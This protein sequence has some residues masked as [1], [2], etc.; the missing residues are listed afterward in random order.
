MRISKNRVENDTVTELHNIKYEGKCTRFV[1]NSSTN[2]SQVDALLAKNSHLD[3]NKHIQVKA[4]TGWSS[5]NSNQNRSSEVHKKK[6]TSTAK[7]PRY[8]SRDM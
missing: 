8:R 4:R 1:Y 2:P 5:M 3:S 7:V 6:C